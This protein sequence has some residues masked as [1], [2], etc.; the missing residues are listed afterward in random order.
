MGFHETAPGIYFPTESP[1][2]IDRAQSGVIVDRARE[3][4][5]KRARLCVHGDPQEQLHEML[6][7]LDKATYV[8][9][10]K[11]SGP[12]SIH[13][14]SGACD[15]VMF[16][17][18]G[19]IDACIPLGD[20]NSENVFLQRIAPSIYHTMIVRSERLIFHETTLG[21]FRRCNTDFARWAPEDRDVEAVR[22]FREELDTRVLN[23]LQRAKEPANPTRPSRGT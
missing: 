2:G 19:R 23:A 12:E 14:V 15:L 18:D 5:A 4:A 13:V 3:V 10:H 9:P 7:C 20:Y 17:E 21:P 6:I 11:H 16:D 1:V 22:A 8:R